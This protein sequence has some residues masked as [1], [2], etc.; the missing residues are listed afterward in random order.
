MLLLA[1]INYTY[2][3]SLWH[4][5]TCVGCISAIFLSRVTLSCPALSP[6]DPFPLSSKASWCFSHCCSLCCA[7]SLS[8]GLQCSLFSFSFLEKKKKICA[9][10]V[11]LSMF[12]QARKGQP[13]LLITK[14]FPLHPFSFLAPAPSPS[15]SVFPLPS[16]LFVSTTSFSV[17]L[18]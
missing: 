1:Y 5:H 10:G 13:M 3:V 12:L 17:C 4:F 18:P 7:F 8:P 11:C 16:V 14:Q 6:A 15:L 9:W 2:Q